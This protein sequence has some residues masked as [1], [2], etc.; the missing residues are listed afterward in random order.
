MFLASTNPKGDVASPLP[1]LKLHVFSKGILVDAVEATLVD[2]N[3]TNSPPNVIKAAEAQYKGIRASWKP[4]KNRVGVGG[5]GH[6]GKHSVTSVQV[7]QSPP[8]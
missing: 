5:E 2:V 7:K 4:L 3:E 6:R 1:S 8:S